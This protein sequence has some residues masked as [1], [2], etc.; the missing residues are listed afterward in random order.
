LINLLSSIDIAVIMI[1]AISLSGA[2]PKGAE[3]SGVDSGDVG[4]PL[5]NLNP[6]IEIADL[7]AMVLQVMADFHSL[8][9]EL[10]DGWGP[11]S[12]QNTAIPDD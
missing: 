1:G 4:R 12:V 2:S 10:T 9:R 6:T 5:S 3:V 8:E 11:L 7:Q